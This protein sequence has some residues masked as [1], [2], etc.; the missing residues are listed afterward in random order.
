[1]P[2][3]GQETRE[4]HAVQHTAEDKCLEQLSQTTDRIAFQLEKLAGQLKADR[5]KPSEASSNST[6]M[7]QQGFASITS[8]PDPS[9]GGAAGMRD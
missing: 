2:Q 1:M 3:F 8:S 4:V 9:L 7:T 5:Y 6:Q